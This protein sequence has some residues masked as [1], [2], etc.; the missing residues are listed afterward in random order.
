M[1]AVVAASS[2]AA[3]P[4]PAPT[5]AAAAAHNASICIRI[6]LRMNVCTCLCLLDC[7]CVRASSANNARRLICLNAAAA[8]A[9]PQLRFARKL[10]IFK[11]NKKHIAQQLHTHTHG[12]RHA[13]GP[14]TL[15][16]TQFIT[17]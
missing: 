13:C 12:E 15:W 3:A 14:H 4:P 16:H 1:Q 6:Y 8:A 5:A 17:Q 7:M 9:N 2:S 10:I 11:L